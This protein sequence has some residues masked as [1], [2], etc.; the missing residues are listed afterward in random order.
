ME[1]VEKWPTN[2]P[3]GCIFHVMMDIEYQDGDRV[4]SYSVPVYI[5]PMDRYVIHFE[6]DEENL[7]ICSGETLDSLK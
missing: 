3:V 1:T 6:P 4:H 5:D 2:D 7:V